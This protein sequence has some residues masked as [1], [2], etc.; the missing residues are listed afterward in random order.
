M[1]TRNAFLSIFIII[2]YLCASYL[3]YTLLTQPKELLKNESS[4]NSSQPSIADNTAKYTDRLEIKSLSIQKCQ[5]EIANKE[6][7]GFRFVLTYAF[8]NIAAAPNKRKTGLKIV[9]HDEYFKAI[10]CNASGTDYI[11]PSTST[12]NSRSMVYEVYPD[13]ISEELI[14]TLIS[15]QYQFKININTDDSKEKTIDIQNSIY[16]SIDLLIKG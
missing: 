16:P 12:S 10:G 1:K 15:T 7:Q 6:R 5:T 9:Y 3:G 2:A 8:F 13:N 4:I 11:F 14:D